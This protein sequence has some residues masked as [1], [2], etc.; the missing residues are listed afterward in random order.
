MNPPASQPYYSDSTAAD[1]IFTSAMTQLYVWITAGLLLTATTGFLAHLVGFLATFGLLGLLPAIAIQ[2]G[3]LWMMHRTSES[4]STGKLVG[5]YLAFTGVGGLT[6]SWVASAYRA[7]TILLALALTGVVFV[8]MSGI[9]LTTKKDLTKWGPI[10]SI[11]LL[12]LVGMMIVNIFIGSSFIGWVVTLLLLPVFLGL[13]VYETKH[14]KE[15]ASQAATEGAEDAASK[16]AVSGAV[17]LYLNFVNLFL[18]ILRI[19]GIF[20]KDD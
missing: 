19:T 3:I 8:A 9:G 16:I 18:I 20:S 1:R 13:T 11:G 14:V 2:L 17:G 7:D 5:L 6:L 10:L 4:A 15:L 12:G